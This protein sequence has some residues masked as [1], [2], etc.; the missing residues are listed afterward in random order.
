[1]A[2]I[3]IGITQKEMTAIRKQLRTQT[4]FICV[5]PKVHVVALL[6]GRDMLMRGQTVKAK[7][8][9]GWELPEPESGTP[10]GISVNGGPVVRPK[11]S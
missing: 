8:V 9:K 11:R 4:E 1:M 2:A 7:I 3:E 10:T 6:V 5:D